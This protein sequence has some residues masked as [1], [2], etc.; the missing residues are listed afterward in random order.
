MEQ[1][2]RPLLILEL[3]GS[4]LQVG[5]VVSLRMIPQ[6]AFG[7]L[8]GV[9]ADRY[10]KRF[11]LMLSQAVT[12]AM[13]L[14]LALL[15]LTGRIAV[16]HVFVTAFLAG[17]SMAFNQPARQSL[18]PQLV[19]REILLN[20]VALNIAAMNIMRVL[21]ASLAG[22][23]LIFFDYGQVYLLNAVIFLGVIWT[24]VKIKV[25]DQ[26]VETPSAKK[27]IPQATLLSDFVDGFRYIS[28]HR[29]LLYL[30]GLGLLL[31]IFGLPYQQVFI[32]LLALDVLH[33]GRSG[34]G[35]L[36]AF[37]GIGSL[38]G[39]LTFASVGR[40]SRRGLLLLGLLLLFSASLVLLAQSRWFPLSSLAM[41]ITGGMATA[42]MALT[43]SLL[44]EQSATE[45]HGRV[46]S[47]MS[48]DRGLMSIGAILA[49]GLAETLGPQ[50][51]LTVL[52]ATCAVFA[53]LMFL[54]V[55]SL[56]K[57]P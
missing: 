26:G 31:Y 30:V 41:V 55:P 52:A 54:F 24:T 49:G 57:I 42:F 34:A 8:A 13:H 56:R 9:I 18:V 48:L 37:S 46:M 53:V 32:P 22:L 14:T 3:T 40:L 15:L 47:L 44:L 51:G 20:A 35:W 5:I 28:H 12:L 23:L 19:P 17:A 43:T 29:V 45:Y 27:T 21:G 36:L 33:I 7:L 10:D 11:V 6:L 4:A 16:W 50:S 39:S 25:G 2:V 38:V 1:V